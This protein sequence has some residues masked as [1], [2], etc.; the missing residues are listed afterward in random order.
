M[1]KGKEALTEVAV[2][3]ETRRH[4][5][6]R[7]HRK[8]D[9]LIRRPQ[10]ADLR[11]QTNVTDTN[12]ARVAHA[13]SGGGEFVGVAGLKHGDRNIDPQLDPLPQGDGPHDVA[14]DTMGNEG[15]T[16]LAIDGEH[17]GIEF[18][19]NVEADVEV[20]V[21]AHAG[22]FDVDEAFVRQ[23]WSKAL[24]GETSHIAH[25]G[26]GPGSAEQHQQRRQARAS[27]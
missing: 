2:D 6:G 24:H 9:A 12:E 1:G 11:H 7:N 8:V 17:Q 13:T 15:G 21:V 25:L 3:G 10:D 19:T 26:L 23:R 27:R 5:E 16:S 18:V 20:Q 22:S 4:R 14:M